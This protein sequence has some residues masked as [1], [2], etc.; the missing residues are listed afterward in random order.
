MGAPT[1]PIA[2]MSMITASA[3]VPRGAAASSPIKYDIDEVE[4][5]RISNLAKLHL[6]DAREDLAEVKNQDEEMDDTDES[7]SKKPDED[8]AIQSQA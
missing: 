8:H 3:W 7:E 6:E 1:L 5:A 2:I 4:L